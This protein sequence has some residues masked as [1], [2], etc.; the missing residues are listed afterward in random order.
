MYFAACNRL[1]QQ[2]NSGGVS[3]NATDTPNNDVNANGDAK[4]EAIGL[5]KHVMTSFTN[6][7][8]LFCIV[9][10]AVLRYRRLCWKKKDRL[11]ICNGIKW[12][13]VPTAIVIG[14]IT[15]EAMMANITP[16]EQRTTSMPLMFILK[17]SAIIF[18][19][20]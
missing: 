20:S 15:V 9:T 7:V 17:F 5:I 6:L 8:G 13:I 12:G 16:Q 2:F 11:S 18:L 1:Q 3:A 10:I 19:V 14:F 4:D